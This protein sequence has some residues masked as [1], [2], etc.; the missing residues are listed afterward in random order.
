MEILEGYEVPDFL[1][2]EKKKPLSKRVDVRMDEE[3]YEDLQ[4]IAYLEGCNK[5]FIM[6]TIVSDYVKYY[7]FKNNQK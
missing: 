4:L 2:T 1:L 5:A 6:R 7:L 3:L